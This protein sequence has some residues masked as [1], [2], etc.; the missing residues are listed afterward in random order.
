MRGTR[1]VAGTRKT[2]PLFTKNA[3]RVF[4]NPQAAADS[5]APAP[6]QRDPAR[7][8]RSAP[9][10]PHLIDAEAA[11]GRAGV[12]ARRFCSRFRRTACCHTQNGSGRPPEN[13]KNLGFLSSC[14][15]NGRGPS[16]DGAPPTAYRTC[17][18]GRP[19]ETQS[20]ATSRGLPGARTPACRRRNRRPDGLCGLRRLRPWGSLGN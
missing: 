11:R 16:E 2:S 18:A 13:G 15:R 14:R 6:A 20:G 4:P 7:A 8:H 5:A 3:R 9:E 19:T 17:G 10:L 12:R 1:N